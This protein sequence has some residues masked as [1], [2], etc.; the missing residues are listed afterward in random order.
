MCKGVSRLAPLA[1]QPA[2]GGALRLAG[3]E[4]AAVAVGAP[5]LVGLAGQLLEQRD[6]L[7]E[8]LAQRVPL[9]GGQPRPFRV[10]ALVELADDRLAGRTPGLRRQE[11]A[12]LRARPHHRAEHPGPHAGVHERPG[13]PRRDLGDHVLGDPQE[14]RDP[15]ERGARVVDQGAVA[16]HQHLLARDVLEEV[17]ELAAVHPEPAVVPERRPPGVHAPRLAGAGLH[18]VRARLE[19]VGP[20]VHPVRVGPVHRVAQH[21]DQ[22]G[23]GHVGR[24]PAAGVSVVEVERRAL[25]GEPALPRVLEQV[26]VA[27]PLPDPLLVAVRVP[28]S[29]VRRRGRVAAQVVL[30]L[31]DRAQEELG[32]LGERGVQGRRTGLGRADQQ[33]VGKAAAAQRL[34]RA[35]Q[36][37]N[38]RT[39]VDGIARLSRLALSRWTSAARPRSAPRCARRSGAAPRRRRASGR[40]RPG[41]GPSR[42][43]RGPPRPGRPSPPR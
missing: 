18:D 30:R 32:V 11:L 14:P 10:A 37:P 24:D 33:E 6:V 26:E 28:R 21:G 23:P 42:R 8:R 39:I 12:R 16:E 1:P 34:G 17:G 4:R 31:L 9:L 22:L 29:A 38:H 7:E 15:V 27:L 36:C 5:V 13:V 40:R 2:G 20:Q 25:P 19:P 41:R 3:V 35:G 43:A